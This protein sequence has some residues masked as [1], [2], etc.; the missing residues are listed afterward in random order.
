MPDLSS[1]SSESLKNLVCRRVGDHFVL[2]KADS[3]RTENLTS[4]KQRHRWSHAASSNISLSFEPLMAS[5]KTKETRNLK[6]GRNSNPLGVYQHCMAS[7]DAMS[8]RSNVLSRPSNASQITSGEDISWN[9]IHGSSRTSRLSRVV[10]A[11]IIESSSGFV[12]PPT[13]EV[14]P[15]Q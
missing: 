1:S 12:Q 11:S 3:P 8:S 9:R 4:V 13:S 6:N 2:C 10:S 14:D 5:H 7:G 15:S